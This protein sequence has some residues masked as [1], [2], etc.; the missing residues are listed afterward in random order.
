MYSQKFLFRTACLLIRYTSDTQKMI[1]HKIIFLKL[2]N[3][4][5][6]FE[7]EIYNMQSKYVIYDISN[8]SF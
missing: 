5:D 3:P 4:G 7:I 6:Y 1:E 2:A 8:T